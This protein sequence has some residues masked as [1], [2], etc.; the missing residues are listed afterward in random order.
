MKR[1][2]F[3]DTETTGFE[4]K[5]GHRIIEF[6]AV[7]MINRKLTGNNLHFYFKPDI[8]VEEGAFRVHGISNEFLADKPLFSEKSSEIME[9]LKDAEL[10]I[11]N[12]AFDV[13][14][15]NWELGLLKPN[16]WG[17]I[18]SYCQ[19]LDTLIMAR[20]KHPGQKNSLDALCARYGINNKHRTLHGALL[21][22]E[23]L[24]DVY[25][26][27]TGGQTELFAALS[28]DDDKVEVKATTSIIQNQDQGNQSSIKA[29][30]SAS[31]I[32]AHEAYLALLDKKSNN[33]TLWRKL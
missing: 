27:M 2:L 15:L 5:K 30:L 9:Y 28:E 10:I 29:R 19:V 13:P 32:K 4:Y 23:I 16:N 17:V 11:H 7:E 8:A 31:A 21:D 18:E 14:F 1:Q 26:M 6:G 33:N 24:A 12:A 3:V 25:L 20:K 22:A